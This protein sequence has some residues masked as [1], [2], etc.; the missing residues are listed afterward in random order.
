MEEALFL[1]RFA[2]Q[3]TIVHRREQ[4]RA[5]PI[6]I[7]RAKA[8]PKIAWK[9]SCTLEDSVGGEQLEGLVLRTREGNV[10]KLPVRG[11]FLAIGHDPNTQVFKDFLKLDAAG[12]LVTDGRTR[13]QVQGVFAAG[14]CVDHVYR[15]AVTAAGQ[16]CMAALEAERFLES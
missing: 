4:L 15:Q 13:T 3:V 16:G 10:E 8:N 1:T 5:S 9:L 14:D 6:M 2:S 12:Y 7:E 11:L